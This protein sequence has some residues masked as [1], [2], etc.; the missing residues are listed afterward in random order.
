MFG[1][2]F[3]WRWFLSWGIDFSLEESKENWFLSWGINV[4]S[5]AY[6]LKCFEFLL[7]VVLGKLMDYGNKLANDDPNRMPIWPLSSYAMCA[8]WLG[9]GRC[10]G[11]DP[12]KHSVG[13]E[14]VLIDRSRKTVLTK[15]SASYQQSCFN[16]HHS[17]IHIQRPS[18]RPSHA[19]LFHDLDSLSMQST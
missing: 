6:V 5:A 15:S 10:I 13:R 12:R 1:K 2:A 19:Y 17:F 18:S 16:L 8:T 11:Q 3:Q 9:R 7:E 4:C 14:V